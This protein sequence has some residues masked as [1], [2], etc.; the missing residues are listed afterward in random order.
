MASGIPRQPGMI[1]KMLGAVTGKLGGRDSGSSPNDR[2]ARLGLSQR[3]Q[4]L[5]RLWSWYRSSQYEGRKINWQG[6]EHMD[7]FAREAISSKGFIPPGFVDAGQQNVPLEFRRPSVPYGLAKVIVDRFTGLLFSEDQHPVIQIDGDPVTEDFIQTLA[8]SA[9]LWQQMIQVRTFGGAMGSVAVGFQFIEG[10][11]VIEVHD[12]RWCEPEFAE[13]S[14]FTVRRMEKRYQY[15]QEERD[16]DTGRYETVWYWYRRI[17]DEQNDIVFK[18]VPVGSGDEPQWEIENSVAHGFGFC[19]VVWVQNLPV[20]DEI[21]G[22]PDCHGTFDMMEAI[23]QLLSQAQRG[24]LSNCDPT[25]VITSESEMGPQVSKGSGNALQIPKGDAKYLEMTASGPK[26]AMD[27]VSEL[28][29]MVLEIAQCF[30]DTGAVQHNRT[31]TEVNKNIAPMLAKADVMR[32]QYGERCV[33][34]LLEMMLKAAM[35]LNRPRPVD[36]ENGQQLMRQQLAL[37]PKYVQGPDGTQI[38]QPR[39]PGSG[40]TIQLK[41]PDFFRPSLQDVL[42]AT[43]A[44]TTAKTAG[45]IDNATIA[46]FIA[47]YFDVDD[48]QQMMAAAQEEFRQ[49]QDQLVAGSLATPD[50][51]NPGNVPLLPD[52]ASEE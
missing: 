43:Q 21:D 45:I 19:P 29:T 5:N 51:A 15:P 28:R 9:R 40:G 1:S 47:R 24:V 2:I 41:W 20:Q 34:P 12:P 22:D 6:R 27:M 31:A 42:Q 14:Q 10:K 18:P 37:P 3:S 39:E 23:D 49:Q 8:R 38:A 50:A 25:L 16:P 13:R 33:K 7:Q 44:A 48:P 26:A 17:I 35:D 32:E 30:L 36:G 52:L 4:E 11:P 46:K